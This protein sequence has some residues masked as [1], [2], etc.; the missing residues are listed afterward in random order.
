[1]IVLIQLPFVG[2]YYV[3]PGVN[4][5]R[6]LILNGFTW[7]PTIFL[8]GMRIKLEFGIFT[9]KGYLMKIEGVFI[10]PGI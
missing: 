10:M 3:W 1:M 2:V 5:G 7:T 6:R 9:F 8:I 4:E